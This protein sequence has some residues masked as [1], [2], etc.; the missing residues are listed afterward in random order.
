MSEEKLLTLIDYWI[1]HNREHEGEFR[2]WA[3]RAD[4]LSA[5]AAQQL[6][7]AAAS[8]AEA[9]KSLERAKQALTKGTKEH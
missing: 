9:S 6:R 4:S 8:M 5:R 7:E 1:D 2:D 3:N